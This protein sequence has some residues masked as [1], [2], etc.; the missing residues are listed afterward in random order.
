MNVE[1]W[2]ITLLENIFYLL[3]NE[4]KHF[5]K[6]IKSGLLKRVIIGSK[7]I[8]NYIGFSYNP[9]M[10]K[11]FENNKGRHMCLKGIKV[12]DQ[13]SGMYT[14]IEIHIM[15]N[16]IAGYSTPQIKDFQP[17][18]NRIVV[19]SFQ[20]VYFGNEDYE[21][22]KNMLDETELALINPSDVFEVEIN[23]NIYYHLKDLEDGDFIGVGTDKKMY[24]ITHDPYCITELKLPLK[25]VL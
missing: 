21:K 4:Y 7:I 2:E 25:G 14:G 17:D 10:S 16:L 12:F 22:I 8:P 19:E 24:K 5:G 9:V 11:Q 1:P 6:Q 18:V 20:R 15:H 13:G 23:G 3:P